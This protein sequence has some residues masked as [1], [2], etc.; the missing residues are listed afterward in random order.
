MKAVL[1]ALG[2]LGLQAEPPAVPPPIPATT[3]GGLPSDAKDHQPLL[4]GPATAKEIL[5]HRAVFR[6]TAA[7]TQLPSELKARW[8]AVRQPLTLVAVFGSWCGDSQYQLPD[9]LVLAADPNPFIEIHYLG[10][11]RDKQVAEAAWPKGCPPQAVVRVPTFYL[12]ATQP[13]GAQKLV[14][15]VVENPPRAGQRMAEALVELVESAVRPL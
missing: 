6:D 4:L 5:A 15:T 14:G 9:L 2:T 11:Y 1:L 13:G 7:A 3:P 10:V 8:K 12:F